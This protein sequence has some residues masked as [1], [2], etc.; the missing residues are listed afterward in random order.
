M[1]DNRQEDN[2][3][4]HFKRVAR[5]MVAL[6]RLAT[7]APTVSLH[8]VNR[9]RRQFV[10][11]AA[12][13]AVAQT[14]FPDRVP[15]TESYLRGF[16]MLAKPAVLTIGKDVPP[17]ALT[18]YP[19]GCPVTTV[20]V[21]PLAY[22]SE[23]VALAV[24]EGDDP[25]VLRHRSDAIGSFSTAMAHLIHTFLELSEL[26]GEE[27]QWAAYEEQIRRWPSRSDECD[28]LDLL[29]DQVVSLVP[30]GSVSILARVFDRWCVVMNHESATAAPALGT[31]MEDQSLAYQALQSGQPEFATH[32]GA[33]PKR[34][35]RAEPI[36]KGASMAI[37]FLLHDRR[38]AV[39][40]VTVENLHFFKDSN[41]H[42]LVNLVRIGA[43]RLTAGTTKF[44]VGADMLSHDNAGLVPDLI[45][46]AMVREFRRGGATV[47]L[48]TVHE[49]SALRSRMRMEET[50]SIQRVLNATLNPVRYGYAGV[51]GP[52]SDFVTLV[53]LSGG[54][55][56]LDRY[57][58]AIREGVSR[59]QGHTL[60]V[61][62]AF[63]TVESSTSDPYDVKRSLRL[64]LDAAVKAKG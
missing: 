11:E 4:R 53:L 25:D 19:A 63:Q 10:L 9:H 48:V 39:V 34:V 12:D 38:Q 49:V 8:W 1:K 21:V 62:H 57:K 20:T 2:A 45:D 15:M 3:L 61:A 36:S 33:S 26:A 47:G 58:A 50:K 5:E 60:T 17:T 18:H 44:L 56:E 23:T 16:E 46:R 13:S 22:N 28:V 24:V 7:A 30:G 52:H 31:V 32:V 6:L 29:M 40:L 27:D 37:P 41:R 64:A 59:I 55:E 43:L 42:K 51:C 35:A 54:P 14:S